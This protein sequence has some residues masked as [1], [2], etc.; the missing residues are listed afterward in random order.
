MVGQPVEPGGSL[1]PLVCVKIAKVVQGLK[2][3]L[4]DWLHSPEMVKIAVA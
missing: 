2:I 3:F 4:R 1:N